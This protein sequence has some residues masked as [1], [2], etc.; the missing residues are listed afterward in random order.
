MGLFRQNA[1]V[2]GAFCKRSGAVTSVNYINC[3]GIRAYR[4]DYDTRADRVVEGTR[5][6]LLTPAFEG[7]GITS[8]LV[9]CKSLFVRLETAPRQTVTAREDGR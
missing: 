8:L 2:D 5:P 7:K 4:R 1:V 9:L 3:S 6:E